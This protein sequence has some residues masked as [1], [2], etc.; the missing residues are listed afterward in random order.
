MKRFVTTAIGFALLLTACS[1]TAFSLVKPEVTYA[2][3]SS[4]QQPKLEDFLMGFDEYKSYQKSEAARLAAEQYDRKI[5]RKE[6]TN[7][8]KMQKV[9]TR[10]ERTA[11]HTWYVF[12]GSTPAGWDCS[13]LVAWTY[14][15]MGVK[16]PHSAIAQAKQG[17]F[18]KNPVPGDL[19]AY[20]YWGSPVSTH[21]GIY[22]GNGKVI[23]ALKP[24]TV[25]RIESA[26]HGV[27]SWGMYA[28]YVRIIPLT[29]PPK[30]IERQGSYVP[31]SIVGT[32]S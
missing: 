24:G 12:S 22:I 31:V 29:D 28:R 11:G 10:L 14:K 21:T 5:A 2:A 20:Y 16:L 18:V 25:T 23:H 15:Q 7:A 6:R 9:L 8:V 13:G 1:S 26:E 4:S 32:A 30:R 17:R 19:V 27:V 3:D